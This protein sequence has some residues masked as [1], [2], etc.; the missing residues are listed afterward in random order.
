MVA[1]VLRTL[2]SRLF[3]LKQVMLHF[4]LGSQMRAA[5]VMRGARLGRN[6]HVSAGI[7]V[8]QQ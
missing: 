6:D 3:I 4:Y 7:G 1:S 2:G 5:P 8:L